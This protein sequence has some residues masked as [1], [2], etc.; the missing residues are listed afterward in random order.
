MEIGYWLSSEEH[1][2]NDLVK[3]A[4]QAEKLEFTFIQISDHFHP[5]IDRQG[6]S[7]FIWSVLGGIAQATERIKIQTAVTCP[8]LRI[9]PIIM[10]QAAATVAAMM[11]GRFLFG[12]GTGENL[13]EHILG[14]HWPPI[15]TRQAML[16]EAI[17]LMRLFWQGRQESFAGQYYQVENAR[18]YTLPDEMPPICI[19]AAG[20]KSAA[21]AGR[22]G[23]A[24]ITTS[25]DTDV[26]SAFQEAG[27]KD[28]PRFG[29]VTVCWAENEAEARRTA[30]EIWPIAALPG[31]LSTEL[32]L[33]GYFEQA[34]KKVTEDEI[35]EQVICGSDPERYI[36]ALQEYAQ[37][38]FDHVSLHQVGP[39]QAGF[40]A[41]FQKELQPR[42]QRELQR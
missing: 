17:E 39:D 22:I 26:V 37:A 41:F 18:L 20:E 12:V 6:H 32:A 42:L 3:F 33:P 34:A 9:H 38:G 29:K 11:P 4:R 31:P 14:T 15:E 40:F 30:H 25:P 5:W 19:A 27:G 23:D 13:N 24:L 8:I 28:K 10:A 7:P 21:L 36:A 1:V 2:P 16:E 35:A